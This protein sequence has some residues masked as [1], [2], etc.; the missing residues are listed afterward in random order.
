MYQ[1]RI[2]VGQEAREKFRVSAVNG[3]L[4]R[5]SLSERL[6]TEHD[7]YSLTELARAC[8]SYSSETVIGG[9]I[10]EMVGRAMTTSDFPAIMSDAANKSLQEGYETEAQT[11]KDFC[12]IGSAP[13]FKPSSLVS[14]SGLDPLEEIK[15]SQPYS[16]G[17]AD[18]NKE[19]VSLVTYGKLF[20]VTRM[21]IINDDIEALKTIPYA[22]GEAAA[23]KIGDLAFSVLTSNPV[24]GDGKTLFHADH[25]NILT[26]A[27]I[28]E[29]SLGEAIKS[30]RLQKDS[31]GRSLNIRPEILVAPVSR[32]GTTEIF[33]SSTQ[34]SG[35][36][37]DSTRAN[38]YSGKRFTRVYDARL[39]DSSIST[40]YVLAAPSKTIKLFFL[41]GQTKPY[42]EQQSGWE[43]DGVEYKV[44]IDCA[45]KALDWRGITR[46]VG[47]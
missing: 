40:W 17:T 28:S 21:A 15:E 38:I 45:A 7:N 26:P 2:V 35:D 18:E 31:K 13:N 12:S 44:R 4:N 46:N 10:M 14:L 29:G 6:E 41:N 1:N 34:F 11:W 23:R 33:F 16:Y 5:I 27:I 42:L 20:A 3:L 36:A 25:G 37:K 43:V 22:Q 32:E 19:T 8:L 39:D 24:M 30:M 47:V 9:N